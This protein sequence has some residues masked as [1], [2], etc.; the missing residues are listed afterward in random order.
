[1]AA[2]L[3]IT[4]AASGAL[5]APQLAWLEGL[6]ID[7][8]FWLR[9]QAYGPA[10][11]PDSSPTVVIAIDEETYRRKPFADVP[12]ALWTRELAGVLNEV[13]A[14]GAK[15][16]G[17]DVI[18]PT[19]AERFLP[20]FDREFL[21]ALRNAARDNKIVLGKV[22]HQQLPIRPFPGQ[23]FAVGHQR[24]IR[25]VNLFRDEDE[26]IR[27]VPLYF[28]SDDLDAGKRSETSLAL[29]LAARALGETP[30]T[31]PD[32]VVRLGA[33]RI[34]GSQ[35]NVLTANFAGGA[36]AGMPVFS[37]ADLHACAA[38][39]NQAFFREKFSGKVVLVG[40]ILDVEDRK[41]TS[42]RFITG[43]EGGGPEG[44]GDVARCVHPPMREIFHQDV[45]RDSIPGVLV[46]ATAVNNLLRRDALSELAPQVYMAFTAVL[47][48][49][50]SV[51]AMTLAPLL[52]GLVIAGGIA[53]WAGVAAVAVRG[54]LVL[55]LLD[56]VLAALLAFAA[57]LG[58]RF[59]VAER[60]KR[61]L[62]SSFSLYLAPAVV[63]RLVESDRP[64]ALGGETRDVSVLFSDIAGFTAIAEKLS[65]PDL[66]NLMNAYL[67]E[68]TEIVEA[69][70]GFVDKYIGDAIVAVFGAPLDDP[71]HALAAVRVALACQH[72]LEELN[73]DPTLFKG[74]LLSARIGLSTGAALVGN[75]G[76][77]R[78]FNYTVMGDTV[79]L[80]SRLE[81][82]NKHYGTRILAS[83]ATVERTGTGMVWREIDRV[84]VI[85]RAQQIVIF[86]PLGPA[87]KFMV[88]DEETAT[89]Y[90][91]ALADYRAG[92]FADAVAGF[93]A[94]AGR[95][96]PAR[97]LLVRARA[98]AADPPVDG[99]EPVTN[100]ESK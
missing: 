94:L 41:L 27:R 33:W 13:V 12:V 84:R 30:E 62:R 55:P 16:V 76:S 67:S 36:T 78:R 29:E 70:G 24:N 71:G 74:H 20:G 23:S 46:H 91:R 51:P 63:D 50:A 49:A 47:A 72:R 9:D 42:M 90:A 52:A 80:A 64:P 19:S 6:S 17:F 22:Q 57:L 43:P 99:W 28:E 40:T 7:A 96:P 54:G 73:R 81:G 8:L 66:V 18:L 48:L 11:A 25:S 14:G 83:Q 2:A 3:A 56:P 86:T 88:G 75:I 4:L 45:V 5:A 92:R 93:Q 68:M 89:A 31:E 38:I 34:P 77:R 26:V 85:G 1:M 87:G 69:E 44:G 58:Y 15:V 95:D 98:L 53:A 60:D 82:A 61:Q 79:N 97:A 100:L 35:R 59:A 65:A 32:G 39:G 21:V 10:H 37:L